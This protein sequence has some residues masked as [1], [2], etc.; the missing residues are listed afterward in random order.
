MITIEN[1]RSKFLRV[2]SRREAKRFLS[3]WANLRDD[4]LDL[5][6]FESGNCSRSTDEALRR[7]FRHSAGILHPLRWDDSSSKLK[8]PPNFPLPPDYN[9]ELAQE[10]F[11]AHDT[12]L[13]LYY[14]RTLLRQ[15]WDAPD[16]RT[17]DW[18][19]FK[20]RGNFASKT[21]VQSV[22]AAQPAGQKL[23]SPDLTWFDECPS[24]TPFEA[25]LFYFQNKIGDLARHCKGLGCLAPYFIAGTPWGKYCSTAC[26]GP[27]NRESKRKWA[28]KSRQKG[29]S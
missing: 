3:E 22:A 21:K 2:V 17:R 28:S 18:Y 6:S 23:S 10:F 12:L 9:R 1:E 27:A 20:I 26:S 7:I 4:Q 29:K 16:E 8:P 5:Q 13:F 14:G 24:L 19:V 11:F 15:A 25:T